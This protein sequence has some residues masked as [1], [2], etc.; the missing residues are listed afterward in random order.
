MLCFC[1]AP[2]VQ[3]QRQRDVEKSVLTCY[4]G[5]ILVRERLVEKKLDFRCRFLLQRLQ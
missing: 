5:R 3:N 4:N 1:R 2:L